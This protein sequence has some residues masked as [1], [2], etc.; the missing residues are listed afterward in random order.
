MGEIKL[1]AL[2]MDGT[3][4]NSDISLAGQT[5][6]AIQAVMDYGIKIVPC[7]GRVMDEVPRDILDIPGICHAITS[8]GAQVTDLKN[9]KVLYS[10]TF[11]REELQEVVEILDHYDLMIEAYIDG[12]IWTEARCLERIWDYNVKEEYW[13]MFFKTRHAAPSRDTFIDRILCSPVEKFNIFFRHQKERARLAEQLRQKTEMTVICAAENNLE[14]NNPT[15][16]KGDG[17]KH[18]CGRLNISGDE[19]MAIG[20]SNNDIEMLKYAGLA[21][22]MGNGGERVKQVSDYVTTTNDD[23]GVALAL[24]RFILKRPS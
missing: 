20:D 22:A 15:A 10:N 9:Q 23:G 24:D 14:I 5:R 6:Q 21:V 8:N 3:T 19:V 16:N 1:V 18:L 12:G 2:D 13:S 7:T 17:L 4:L 11:K